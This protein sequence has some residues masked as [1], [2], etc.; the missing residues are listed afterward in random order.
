MNKIT[1]LLFAFLTI[2][3]INSCSDDADFDEQQAEIAQYILDEGLTAVET[4]EGEG[5]WYAITTPGNGIDFPTESS[6]VT[7]HYVGR[8]LDGTKFDSSYDR[9]QPLTISL[10]NVITGW[11]RGIPK[12]KK[13][14][15]GKLMIPSKYAYGANG[16]GTIPGNAILV[17]DIELID[18]D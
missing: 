3:T 14:D 8:L 15:I 16:S 18:F 5:I 4:T 9:G 6:D 10:S 11:R 2:V 7:V 13:G 1:T 12:F 17:F